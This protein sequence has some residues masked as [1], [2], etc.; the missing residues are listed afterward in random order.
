MRY[1]HLI[2]AFSAE[3][4]AILPE[5]LAAI[6]A[7]LELR[8]LGGSVSRAD[9]D[10]IVAANPRPVQ[11][12]SGSVAVLP[13]FGTIAQRANLVMQ[14]SGGTSTELLTR[15]LRAALADDSIS[16]IILN[17]D[18][19]GGS[20]Y[21]VEEL[22]D[23]IFSARGIKPIVAVAN[24]LAASA[25][26]WLGSQADEFVVTPSGEVGS[27]GVIAAHVDQSAANEQ[28]GVRVSYVTAGKYKAENNPDEP[29]SEEGRGHLQTRVNDYYNAF[30]KAV[31]RGRG[32]KPAD[33]AGGMGEGRVVGAAE[34]RR[35]GMVDR[36][37]T[38][39]QTIARLQ[40]GRGWTRG[41]AAAVESTEVILADG[42]RGVL[43]GHTEPLYIADDRSEHYAISEDILYAY[44]RN[45]DA[46]IAD[47]KSGRLQ[48]VPT[49]TADGGI[50]LQVV[51]LTTSPEVLSDEP[52][53]ATA[54][55]GRDSAADLEWR[56]RRLRLN[57]HG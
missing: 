1:A 39:D 16:S 40:S 50:V 42:R 9:I 14:A 17:I 43:T 35:L 8:A 22:A 31:A 45:L 47:V 53:T 30:V 15:D 49:A 24:S 38:L 54:D 57:G 46:V 18:S 6:G 41:R 7:L 2:H 12:T 51:Q 25:A 28:M 56:R 20:V 36:I 32:V 34:A 13:V 19:P 44:D 10:A 4:W 27:I 48:T 26:Y 5:K 21:G 33:V 52:V 11:R 55:E 23:V 37:E 3:P 29:L